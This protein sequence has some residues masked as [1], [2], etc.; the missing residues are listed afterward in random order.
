MPVSIPDATLEKF[1]TFGDLLRFLRRRAGITQIDLS[2]TVGYSNAQISRLE[3]N[4]RLPD[5]PTIEARFVPALGLENEPKV[6]ARL[7]DLAANVRRE[8]A[9]GLG[10]CPYKGLN[11]FDESD[12]DLFVGREA[13]TVK[14]TERVFALTSMGARQEMRFLAIIGASGCGKSSLVRAGLIP[15][16]RWNLQTADWQT[17]VFTP[18]V[19]PLESLSASLTAESNS[20]IA[21]STLIDDLARDP[22][23]LHLYIKRQMSLENHRHLL[24]VI[25]Q[26]EELFALCR[27]GDERHSFINNLLTAA[28]EADGPVVVIITL[29]ADFYD[30]CADYPQL[31]EALALNQEYIGAMS[32]DE[33]RRAIEE[34]ALHGR[35][36][37]EPGLLDLLLHDVEGEPGALPLLSHALLETWERRRGRSLTLSGYASSGGVRGAIAE[38]AETVFTDQLTKK[39]QSIARRI[40]LRLTELGDETSLIDTRRRAKFTEL[41]LNPEEAATTRKVLKTL[42][43]ARLIITSEDSAEVAHEALIREWPTLRNWLEENRESLRLHQQL[44]ESVQEWHA[45]K[46]SPDMLYRGA[47]LAQIQ[48]WASNHKEEMNSLEREFLAASVEASDREAAEREAQHRRELEAARELTE[49]QVRA[50]KQLRKRAFYLTGAL[51]AA[52]V[53]VFITLLFGARARQS[54]T[55]AHYQERIAFSRELAAESVNNLEVD[56]ERSILLALAAADETRAADGSVL[57]EVVSALHQ[58][59]QRM[60]VKLILEPAGAAAFSQDGNRIATAGPDNIV[61][62]WDAKTGELLQSLAG[63]SE[64]VMNVA[65]D[66]S[67]DR[68][69]STSMDKT[70]RV[71]DLELGKAI[72]ILEGHTDGLISSVYSPDGA[73]IVTTSFDGSARL[74][75]AQTGELEFVLI[76]SG[77]TLGPHF[78]PDGSL[79]AIA[80]DTAV[81]A[82]IWDTRTSEEVMRLEGHAEGLNEVVFSPDGSQLATAGSDL[83]VK[84]WDARTG[85]ELKTFGGHTGWVFTV[86][87]SPDGRFLISGSQDGTAK[88]WDIA[89]GVELM[90]LAGHTGGVGEVSISPDG[91]FVVTGSDD[92]TARVWDITPEGSRDLR[93]LA[94]HDDVVLEVTISPDGR[95]GATASWDGT[96]KVWDLESGEELMTLIGH[97]DQLGGVAFS[98][99]GSLLATAS[100]DGTVR[101]WNTSSG[102][103]IIILH[104]HEGP[105]TGVA[106]S[107][108]GEL[109]ATGGLDATARLWNPKTGEVV[110]IIRGH[111][112]WVFRIAF[113]PNGSLLATASWDGTAKLWNVTSGKELATLY[114]HNE[115]VTGIGYSTDGAYIAT[116]SFDATVRIWKLE[117]IL[118]NPLDEEAQPIQVLIGHNGIVWDAAFSPDSK[119]IATASFDN[120]I[121]LWDLETAT[122]GLTLSAPSPVAFANVAFSPDGRML[123][124][125]SSDGSVRIFLLPVEDLIALARERV[126]RSFTETECQQY[127]HMDSCSPNP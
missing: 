108:D 29:R 14:L 10:L 122:E 60:R 57:P 100:Y 93:T 99:D 88:V 74:W 107:P 48:E 27:S 22:R 58:G 8:D 124:G 51:I 34:P 84:L 67:D 82:R 111:K 72:L 110:Q 33:L 25:D 39:Q 53:M 68:L 126:T 104:G 2:I 28:S 43:D 59:L 116:S 63:H 30:R 49:V 20:V 64:K 105:V 92:G 90:T 18:S 62:I 75:D 80:D 1:T 12:A 85:T 87:F 102:E 56:P 97:T 120:T 23:S 71:W 106:F 113:S 70:A 52:L 117:D 16:L 3:Q 9:P 6:V 46:R 50:A 15:A 123:A 118:N 77:P 54:A 96:A 109:L 37:L 83:T 11:Y 103:E 42:A 91:K 5:I 78:S 79:V 121:K 101:T 114:G 61:R 41:I 26:F 95:L 36:G 55:A 24:L 7:L 86:G 89:S 81:I 73:Q 44:T 94:E 40:F 38:T 45:M 47:R 17:Y 13:L 21:T 32:E 19:H 4:L 112:D 31:R 35:W 76:H 125:S 98:P 119:V 115:A 65:F 127:L 69:I 66:P